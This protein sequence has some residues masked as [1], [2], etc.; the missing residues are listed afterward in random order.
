MLLCAGGERDETETDPHVLSSLRRGRCTNKPTSSV[1]GVTLLLKSLQGPPVARTMGSKGLC[2]VSASSPG[3]HDGP[4]PAQLQPLPRLPP[5]L[6]PACPLPMPGVSAGAGLSSFDKLLPLLQH[7][8][9]CPLLHL[10]SRATPRTIV[11][12]VL[13]SPEHRMQMFV[14]A[15]I[16]CRFHVH[17]PR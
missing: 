5:L 10:S 16:I 8:V 2:R 13:V 1:R 9:Q 4:T 11:S 6:Q 3:S 15:R 17:P 14:P 7:P 12:F